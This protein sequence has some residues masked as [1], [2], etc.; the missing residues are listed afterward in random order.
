[1]LVPVVT[2][3]VVAVFAVSSPVVPVVTGPVIMEYITFIR[4]HVNKRKI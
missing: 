1:M 3:P 4:I 2:G